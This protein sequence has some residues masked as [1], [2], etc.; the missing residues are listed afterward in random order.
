MVKYL[1]KHKHELTL[2][3]LTTTVQ[4]QMKMREEKQYVEEIGYNTESFVISILYCIY[5]PNLETKKTYLFQSHAALQGPFLF[6]ELAI[7][8][9]YIITVNAF[10]LFL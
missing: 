4:Y 8:V 9:S 7:Y 1:V 10:V 5:K 2:H 6:W 3:C